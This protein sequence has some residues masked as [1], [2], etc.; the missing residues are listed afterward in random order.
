MELLKKLGLLL[1]ETIKVI[2]I[3]FAIILPIR[4]FLIQPFYVEG[5]SMEP[6]FHTKEYLIID[7]ISYR[8]NDPARGDVVVMRYP[9]DT[10]QYFIKRVMGLPGERIKIIN[11]VV[12]TDNE[13]L[14]ESY[15]SEELKSY[16]S[17]EE[18]TLGEDEYFVL[19]DNR[20]NSL[21]SRV[22]GP[23]QRRFIVGRAWIRGWPFDRISVFEAPDY[24]LP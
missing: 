5:A 22:F 9:R 8:F 21:D 19:G 17:M 14:D 18:L 3:S 15:L 1:F 11:G 4:Y 24:E 2:V 12:F 6:S 20:A 7:E 16:G 10:R 23:V 13:P